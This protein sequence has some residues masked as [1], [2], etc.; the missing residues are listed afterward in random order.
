[1]I[2]INGKKYDAAKMNFNAVCQLEEYGVSLADM[3]NKNFSMIRAYFGLC[4]GLDV[5]DAGSELEAHMI[6]GGKLD[7]LTQAMTKE[8]N[9]SDFFQAMRK[10]AETKKTEDSTEQK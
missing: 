1:M 5:D 7:E 4:S 10:T 9:E 8:L 3:K 2:K 6:S